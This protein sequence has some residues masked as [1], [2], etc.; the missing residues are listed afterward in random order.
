MMDEFIH[1]VLWPIAGAMFGIVSFVITVYALAIGR[2][3]ILQPLQRAL[4]KLLTGC[5]NKLGVFRWW[6]KRI[7][8]WDRGAYHD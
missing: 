5:R 7:W 2:V 6:C 8:R 3:W 1:I 4:R